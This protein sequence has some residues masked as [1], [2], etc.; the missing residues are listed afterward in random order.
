MKGKLKTELMWISVLTV[1][2]NWEMHFQVGVAY[3]SCDTFFSLQ[4]LKV[5]TLTF[6]FHH[7]SKHLSNIHEVIAGGWQ[8]WSKNVHLEPGLPLLAPDN[9]LTLK[10]QWRGPYCCQGNLSSRSSGLLA[11]RSSILPQILSQ[12]LSREA[13]PCLSLVA[14]DLRRNRDQ[15]LW[16]DVRFGNFFFSAG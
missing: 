4:S 16:N 11:T 2:N 7:I 12:A 15:E 10:V 14:W 1:L 3:V 5:E 9:W 8:H 13:L 6:Q